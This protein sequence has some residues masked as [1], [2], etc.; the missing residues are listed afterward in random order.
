MKWGSKTKRGD[1]RTI[2]KFAFFPIR[3][4]N[5]WNTPE[6]EWRWLEKVKIE[7]TYHTCVYNDSLI[8]DIKVFL[9]G[10]YWTNKR[11]IE[12]DLS[13]KREEKL[14]KLGI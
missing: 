10:G 2:K 11:F 4:K 7:Q 8:K 12:F 14:K 3:I 13:E 6:V 5:R 9:F 1:D